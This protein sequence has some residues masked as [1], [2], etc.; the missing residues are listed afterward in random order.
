MPTFKAGEAGEYLDALNKHNAAIRKYEMA[1]DAY[2]A[3]RIGDD[4]YL[5]AREAYDVAT[6]E[7]DDAYAK[8]QAQE[9]E[10]K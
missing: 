7:F 6:A 5:A 3:K 2:R 10:S 4:V 1:R 8:A 9:E